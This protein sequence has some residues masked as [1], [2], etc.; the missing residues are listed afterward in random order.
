MDYFFL[1]SFVYI[2]FL[3]HLFIQVFNLDFLISLYFSQGNTQ[4]YWHFVYILPVFIIL[5]PLNYSS[6]SNARLGYILF[7]V[8]QIS[9][10]AKTSIPLSTW[11]DVVGR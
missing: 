9:F 8:Y 5:S 1:K 7:P 11:G 4:K 3:V 10:D 2:C 6:S